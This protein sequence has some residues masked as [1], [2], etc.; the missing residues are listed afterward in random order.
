MKTIFGARAREGITI[1]SPP[2]SLKGP[3]QVRAS[4]QE[5]G[6]YRYTK[7]VLSQDLGT[8]GLGHVGGVDV[9]A[10]THGH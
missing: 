8:Q 5:I 3:A 9:P 4:V 2:T 10:Q 1:K 7:N 6:G